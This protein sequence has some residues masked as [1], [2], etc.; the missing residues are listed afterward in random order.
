MAAVLPPPPVD[1]RGC[2]SISFKSTTNKTATPLL[3]HEVL[4][5]FPLV[6]LGRMFKIMK[7]KIELDPQWTVLNGVEMNLELKP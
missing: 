6:S 4:E 5:F 1:E 3:P 7:K 2:K